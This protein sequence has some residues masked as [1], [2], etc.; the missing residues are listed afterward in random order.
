MRTARS[1]TAIPEPAFDPDFHIYLLIGQSNMEGAPR[2]QAQDAAPDP[3][4]KVL[5]Y[6]YYPRLGRKY[7]EWS[8][9]V[10][11][12]HS[13][14]LGVGPG[15][16]FAKSLIASMPEG[17]TIGLVPCA[18]AG[19]DIDYFRK[20]VVSS[21]R[22]EFRIPPDNERPGAYEW[23]LERAR[24]AQKYGVI[25]G[26]LFHQGESDNGSV[27]WIGKVN[28]MVADLR[29]DLGIPDAPILIGELLRGG[30]CEGHNQIIGQAVETIPKA[31]LV[32]SE[33][34]KGI[35]QFHF[36]LEAQR[37]LGRRYA[38]VMLRALGY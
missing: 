10:P 24:I 6:A 13:I 12:L 25:K 8:V 26:I 3:R 37:E 15:D 29:S 5:A 11:P 32:S 16:Y 18:I 27:E 31:F 30:A 17:V 9:A 33:G 19:V 20:G 4:V 23:V 21:R 7:N 34:L 22:S 1:M 36:N 35:D 38:E 14:N 28:G 2:P